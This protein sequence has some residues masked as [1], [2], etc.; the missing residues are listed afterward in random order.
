[1]H[2]RFYMPHLACFDNIKEILVKDKTHL[3][4]GFVPRLLR[5]N[6]SLEFIKIIWSGVDSVDMDFYHEYNIKIDID[7]K[8]AEIK[9]TR[10]ESFYD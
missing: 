9:L 6:K 1:M 10:N 8:N 2:D 7:K 4:A 5:L 3:S